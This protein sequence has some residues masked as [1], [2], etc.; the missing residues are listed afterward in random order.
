M[1]APTDELIQAMVKLGLTPLE[2]RLYLL[3]LKKPLIKVSKVSEELQILGP[4]VHRSL[5]TLRQKQLIQVYGK[6]PLQLRAVDPS[7]ALHRQ[8]EDH[9]QESILLEA[10]IVAA[11]RGKAKDKSELKIEFLENKEA[12]FAQ[13]LGLIQGISYEMMILSLGEN[14]PEDVFVGITRK[15]QQGKTIKMLAEAYSSA[16]KEMLTNWVRNG[17]QVRY[18]TQS[19]PDFTLTI[20]DERVAVIQVRKAM[21]RDIRVGI[22]IY[23]PNYAKAQKEYFKRL[24]E[25]GT[26]IT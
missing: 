9:Y 19:V 5:K 24:W 14:I 21:A 20:Y 1:G 11:L 25:S 4:S 18:L 3:V 16:N 23:N 26:Q 10:G 17:W 6:K 12:I 15:A 7:I 22:A 2:A 8:I 13:A